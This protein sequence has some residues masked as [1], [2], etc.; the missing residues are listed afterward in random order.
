MKNIYIKYWPLLYQIEEI[1]L[2]NINTNYI[3][4]KSIYTKCY[5]LLYEEEKI[6][7]SKI[8]ANHDRRRILNRE[9]ENEKKRK[10]ETENEG[11]IRDSPERLGKFIKIRHN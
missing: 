4:W 8:I 10:R 2:P 3:K 1:F 6:V 11:E 5:D 7:G 9:I